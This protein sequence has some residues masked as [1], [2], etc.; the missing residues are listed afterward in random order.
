MRQLVLLQVP[1]EGCVID[2]N[3]HGLLYG[4]SNTVCLPAYN[5]KAVYID[6]ICVDWLCL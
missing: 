6:A 5:G 1:V 3:K 4:P 2:L